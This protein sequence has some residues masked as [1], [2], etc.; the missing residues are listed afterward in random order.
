MNLKVKFDE[1]Q[2]NIDIRKKIN[3]KNILIYLIINR[4]N[5]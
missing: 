3:M 1:M 4:L 2:E 5:K